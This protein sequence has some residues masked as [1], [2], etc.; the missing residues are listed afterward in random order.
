M[1][2]LTGR[3]K[4]EQLFKENGVTKYAFSKKQFER[5]DGAYIY[6]GDKY[7]FEIKDRYNNFYDTL[8]LQVDKYQAMLD[9]KEKRADLKD[10]WYINFMKGK[11]YAFKLEDVTEW[12]KTNKPVKKYCKKTTEFANNQYVLKDVYLLPIEMAYGNIF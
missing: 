9:L 8:I 7:Y 12:A 3:A 1:S 10:C 5:T 11:M 6:D 2:E 4:L